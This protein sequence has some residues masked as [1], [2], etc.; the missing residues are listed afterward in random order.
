MPHPSN[1][2]FLP[3]WYDLFTNQFY[4]IRRGLYKGLLR[5][6]HFLNGKMLDFGCGNKPYASIINVSEHIGLDYDTEVSRRN[7][8]NT[9]DV[10]YDGTTIPFPDNHFDSAFS[11]EVLEHVFN[12]DVILPE[13]L[14]VLKP[15]AHLLLSCPFYWPEHEQPYDYARYTSFGLRHLMEKNDFEVVHYEKTGSYL[16]CLFQGLATYIYFFIPHCPRFL[17]VIFFTIFIT[18]LLILGSLLSAVLPKKIKRQDFYLN[19]I[20]VVRKKP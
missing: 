3:R 6:R 1:T 15:G 10:F 9:V 17:E 19:N 16:E 18:P 11:S 4:F 2:Y 7:I 8:L 12:P 5:N 13:I 20:I 14:R